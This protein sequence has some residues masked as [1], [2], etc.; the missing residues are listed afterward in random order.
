MLGGVLDE[1]GAFGSIAFSRKRRNRSATS[2]EST[3]R[4]GRV[5]VASRSGLWTGL[6][7]GAGVGAIAGSVAGT[8]AGAG[9]GVTGVSG[10][11]ACA[12]T[13]NANVSKCTSLII[14]DIA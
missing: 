3:G 4:T 1:G 5:R 12:F 9:V 14:G 7:V 11:C 13:I 2:G 8:V 10:L 6:E